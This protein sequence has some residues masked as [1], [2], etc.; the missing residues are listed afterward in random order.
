MNKAWFALRAHPEREEKIKCSLEA[1]LRAKGLMEEIGQLVVPSETVSEVKNGESKI[2]ESHMFPGY[3]FIELPVEDET[4]EIPKN[5][6]FVITETPGI[7]GFVGTSRTKP[8]QIEPEEIKR[9]LD[10]IE[11]HKIR[12]KPKVEFEVGNKVRIKDGIFEGYDGSVASVDPT[13]W[14]LKVMTA[15]FGRDTEVEL[16]YSKVERI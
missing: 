12:P 8:D 1:R 2:S 10:E 9:I 13:K 4:N 16:E 11:A 7:G 5:L 3:I 15:I 6:W 14:T